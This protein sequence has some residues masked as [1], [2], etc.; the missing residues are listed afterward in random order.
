MN[1]LLDLGSNNAGPYN[2][3]NLPLFI[4][5]VMSFPTQHENASLT[6]KFHRSTCQSWTELTERLRK[7]IWLPSNH[8]MYSYLLK[9]QKLQLLIPL[10]QYNLIVWEWPSNFNLFSWLQKVKARFVSEWRT[11]WQHGETVSWFPLCKTI[12]R[13]CGFC[14]GH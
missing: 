10:Y 5:Q 3:N 14:I 1:Y 13:S 8:F 4:T 6:H 11:D 9:T 12:F 7:E 2:V